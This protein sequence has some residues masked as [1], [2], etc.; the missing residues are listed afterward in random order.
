MSEK[1]VKILGMFVGRIAQ[2]TSGLFSWKLDGGEEYWPRKSLLNNR[3]VWTYSVI[4]K[5]P[6]NTLDLNYD[7]FL[8]PVALKPAQ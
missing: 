6:S 8:N 4:S 3:K 2:K 5:W 7:I 1:D